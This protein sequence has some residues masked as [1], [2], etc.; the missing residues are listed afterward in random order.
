MD[1]DQFKR[2]LHI[3]PAGSSPSIPAGAGFLTFDKEDFWAFDYANCSWE[4]KSQ[5]PS[6]RTTLG[7]VFDPDIGQ[8]ILFGG[9]I[10]TMS[11]S[12]DTW[13]YDFR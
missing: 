9:W 10:A 13:T 7:M 8:P 3:L 4:Q 2:P 6:G 1:G 12:D 5:C 11:G